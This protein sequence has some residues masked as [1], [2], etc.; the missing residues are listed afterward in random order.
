MI[1]NNSFT[2]WMNVILQ[3]EYQLECGS[4][5]VYSRIMLKVITP[6]TENWK[7]KYNKIYNSH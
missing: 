6:Y 4:D 3:C 5:S 7:E 1:D 2:E